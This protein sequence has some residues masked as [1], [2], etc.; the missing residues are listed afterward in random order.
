MSR[1]ALTSADRAVGARKHGVGEADIEHAW[2]NATR[3]IEYE[4]DGEECHSPSG[5][6]VTG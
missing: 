2:R 6:I 4:Y 3:L 1:D 5:P